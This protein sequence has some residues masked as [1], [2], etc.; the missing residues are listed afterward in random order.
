MSQSGRVEVVLWG[1]YVRIRTTSI[2]MFQIEYVD[3]NSAKIGRVKLGVQQRIESMPMSFRIYII[4]RARLNEIEV[5]C[6]VRG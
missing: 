6:A 1:R 2:T 4:F 3:L 5:N